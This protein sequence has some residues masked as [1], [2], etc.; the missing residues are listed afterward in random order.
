MMIRIFKKVATT[1]KH[2]TGLL[3]SKKG[4]AAILLTIT[5]SC[6]V[7]LSSC[8]FIAA[9]SA[10]GRSYT[11][12]ALRTAGRSVMSEYDKTLLKDYGLF[13]FHSDERQ[14]AQDITFYA[15][16]S[17]NKNKLLYTPLVPQKG[18]I[19]VFN[20]G[21]KASDIEVNLKEYSLMSAD[22]F[23]RQIKDA[24]GAEWLNDHIRPGGSSSGSSSKDGADEER[25]DRTLRNP[26]I[27][28]ALP[29]AGLTGFSWPDFS[30]IDIPSM[31]EVLDAAGTQFLVNEYIMSVFNRAYD[32][33][34][35]P[36]TFFDSEVEYIIAGKMSEASN[37]SSVM[38]RIKAMR[39]VL[40]NISI[41][42]DSAKMTKITEMAA[43]A[44]AAAGIGEVV[45]QVLITEAWVAAETANDIKLLESGKNVALYKTH[46][47]WALYNI[48]EIYEGT[49][50]EDEVEPTD[51]SGQDYKGYLRILLYL[52]DRETKLLRMMD[53]IQINMKGTYNRSFELREYYTGYRFETMIKGDRFEYTETY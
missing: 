39:F 9:K 29:S 17:L 22:T 18:A 19:S 32:D 8:L 46:N 3:K 44:A 34:E 2:R 33:Y 52:T 47:S 1:A 25:K 21:K 49:F 40:N 28:E 23:E 7:L 20:I 6:M 12:A 30:D 45:A 4:G 36:K 13:A 43:P 50:T 15:N 24:A 11:D 38:N 35:D 27:T 48:E 10:A 5:F 51:K 16:A 37:E 14:I 26:S 31:S 41:L 53:L 42:T